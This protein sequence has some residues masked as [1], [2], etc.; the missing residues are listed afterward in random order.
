MRRSPAGVK[1]AR[2]R[3]RLSAAFGRSDER[4]DG[5]LEGGLG[6]AFRPT[7]EVIV[8]LREP[9]DEALEVRGLETLELRGELARLEGRRAGAGGGL[10]HAGA[11]A[12][13]GIE[14]HELARGP[15]EHA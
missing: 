15:G 10:V 8:E 14:A 9:E 13:R 4:E 5:V 6:R 11:G 3:G 12:Q 7:L 1:A 2:S